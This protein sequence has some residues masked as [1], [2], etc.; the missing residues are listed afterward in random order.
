MSCR[1]RWGGG[2]EAA[3]EQCSPVTSHARANLPDTARMQLL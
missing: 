3:M 2:G 1:N